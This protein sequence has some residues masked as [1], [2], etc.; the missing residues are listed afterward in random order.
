MKRKREKEED[1]YGNEE[2]PSK[3]HSS[4]ESPSTFKPVEADDLSELSNQE[5]EIEYDKYQMTVKKHEQK[6]LEA[7]KKLEEQ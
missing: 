4:Q 6:R 3:H 5:E 1:I 7:I 2:G